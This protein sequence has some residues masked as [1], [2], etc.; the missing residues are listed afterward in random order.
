M[1]RKR[2][3]VAVVTGAGGGIGSAICARLAREGVV[4][5]AWDADPQAAQP[6][7]DRLT[8]AVYQVDVADPGAV[9]R[10]MA[11]TAAQLGPPRL[12]VNCAGIRDVGDPLDL[13][14]EAWRRV[15]AVNLD[16]ALYCTLAVA[17]Q[18][19][20]AGG[21]SIVNIASVAGLA[22]VAQRTAYVASKSGLIGLTR[23]TAIDLARHG[24]RV[25]AVAPGLVL[26]PLTEPYADDA[27]SKDMI[28]G[29]PLHRWG[30][31]TEIAEAV[32]FLLSDAA[33]FI[34]GAVLPVDGGLTAMHR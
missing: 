6:V 22:G 10:A 13:T 4:I 29:I 2:S 18:M 23:S 30:T 34:T 3:T 1:E 16:G 7:V 11:D 31:P 25:N 8:G 20:T 33:S 9:D 26:T 24:I 32:A 15:M 21:G 27:G 19:A 14:P 5:A 17:R 12:L 28:A